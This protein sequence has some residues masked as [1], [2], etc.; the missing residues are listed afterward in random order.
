MHKSTAKR[1]F[2][3]HPQQWCKTQNA[4][5]I[6]IHYSTTKAFGADLFYTPLLDIYWN[7]V[8]EKNQLGTS[9]ALKMSV[10]M[11][12]VEKLTN[13]L[14]PVH[15]RASVYHWKLRGGDGESLGKLLGLNAPIILC[16]FP[17]V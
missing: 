8:S 7:L 2:V 4:I 16:E 3:R 11:D 9:V 5:I 10:N 17:G 1:L 6:V 12:L 15:E 14:M 13:F